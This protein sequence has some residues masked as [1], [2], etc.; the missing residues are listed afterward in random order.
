M[1]NDNAKNGIC[2]LL[3]SGFVSLVFFLI[4]VHYTL[5]SNYTVFEAFKFLSVINLIAWLGASFVMSKFEYN[6][7]KFIRILITL[8]SIAVVG[9]TFFSAKILFSSL[10]YLLVTLLLVNYLFYLWELSDWRKLL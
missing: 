10:T 8:I 7:S 2:F 3:I 1:D 5:T 4:C 6:S 9:I